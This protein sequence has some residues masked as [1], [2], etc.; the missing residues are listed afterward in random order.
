GIF[1]AERLYLSD[2]LAPASPGCGGSEARPAPDRRRRDGGRERDGRPEPAAG[3]HWSQRARHT[4][5][6]APEPQQRDRGPQA[7][8]QQRA[9]H[10]QQRDRC[11]Q[12]RCDREAGGTRRGRKRIR[13]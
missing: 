6:R 9:R 8:P 3:S 7:K 1:I 2:D 12:A 11:P 10:S 4:Q 5:Q 13:G